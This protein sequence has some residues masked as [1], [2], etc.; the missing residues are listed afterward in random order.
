MRT[1]FGERLDQH[2][3]ALALHQPPN[4][5]QHHPG[6]LWQL[7]GLPGRRPAQQRLAEGPRVKRHAQ[8]LHRPAQVTLQ[9]LGQGLRNRRDAQALGRQHTQQ[10]NI[11]GTQARLAVEQHLGTYLRNLLQQ[12]QHQPRDTNTVEQH[13]FSLGFVQRLAQTHAQP[14]A[15][16]APEVPPFQRS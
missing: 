13:D 9:R 10:A 15:Q 3:E 8:R 16:Q 7:Q 5:P 6:C 12:R 4:R 2:L 14:W 1:G 11:T